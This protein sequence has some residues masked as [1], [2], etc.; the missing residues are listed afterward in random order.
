MAPGAC[1]IRHGC[2]VLQILSLGVPRRGSHPLRGRS[3]LRWHV[4]GSSFLMNPRPSAIAHQRSSS[5]TLNPPTTLSFRSLH[6]DSSHLAARQYYPKQIV[7]QL[8]FSTSRRRPGVDSLSVDTFYF[9]GNKLLI[10]FMEFSE[11]DKI[12]ENYFL[13]NPK[14]FQQ[15]N[16]FNLLSSLLNNKTLGTRQRKRGK[17]CLIGIIWM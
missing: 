12:K 6:L 16:K 11:F 15:F 17:L 13:T 5:P 4:Y 14:Q 7:G 3:K 2:N 1:K 8:I 10:F 9:V